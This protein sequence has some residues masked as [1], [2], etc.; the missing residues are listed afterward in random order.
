M[1]LLDGA[2]PKTPAEQDLVAQLVPD[3]TE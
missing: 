1:D 3:G 2:K